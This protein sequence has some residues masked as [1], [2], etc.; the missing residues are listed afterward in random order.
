MGKPI[1]ARVEI[2][3]GRPGLTLNGQRVAPLLYGLTD[4][5]G[6]RWS[7]EEVPARNLA[8]FASSGLRLFQADLWFEQMIG[9]D[10]RLDI[11][12]ARR[13]VAG[14]LAACPDAAVML[15]LHVNAPQWWL[16]QHPDE[17]V[18]YADTEPEPEHPWSLQR[19]L[20]QDAGHPRRASFSSRAWL[21]WAGQHLRSFCTDL[22]ATREGGAVFGLQ[23][24][25]GVY[26]EWHQFGFL[27]HD[28]DHGPA[29]TA[30]FRAWLQTRY[31]SEEKLALAWAQP[32]LKWAAITP[33]DSAARETADCGILRDPRRQR[34]VIDYFHFLHGQL[35]D[36]ILALA[37][38]VKESW[39][40]PIITAAFFGYFH[41]MFG[42]LAAGGHL[43]LDRVLASPHL[44]CLCAPQSYVPT[45][46]APGGTGH[47]RGLID[48][49]R[50]AGKLWLDEMDQPTTVSGC[51]WDKTFVNTAVD[52]V[53]VQIRNILQPVT[54]GGGV[55]WYDF[56]PTAGT[57]EAVRYG[58]IGWWDDPRLQADAARLHALVSA[59]TN[60]P[61]ARPADVLVVHDPWSFAHTVGRRIP[62]AGAK[63]GTTPELQGDLVSPIAID[64]LVEGLH[65]SGLIHEEALLSEL[66]LLELAP[67]RLVIFATTP[68]LDT[69]Q[70]DCIRSR[71][72]QD[73]RHIVFTGFT[74]W[75]DGE[76]AEAGCAETTTGFPQRLHWANPATL[77]FSVNGTKETR[78]LSGAGELPSFGETGVEVIG[79]WQDGVA[80][81]V[82]RNEPGVTWW[83]FTVAPS[84]PALL[85]EIGR[86]AGCH[87]VNEADETTLLGAGLL[88]VHTLSGGT[89]TLRPPGGPDI[90]ADLPP[91]SSVVFDSVT[92]ERL[93]G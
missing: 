34:Q 46:R 29:A 28:P 19:P 37:E 75:S 62:P 69:T 43:A 36:T 78:N 73:D 93:H 12:L 51:P 65:Q 76:R 90:V 40:R 31:T 18:G 70:L 58:L 26:G 15:R 10:D 68:V 60:G 33:P 63:F 7:W 32:G 11:T 16:D 6:A 35:A 89:R 85:R 92:G 23:I 87:I 30:A 42:R 5:P 8:L 53:A 1:S 9:S 17:C 88:V 44:D 3:A 13:Q 49:V 47:A 55:W 84:K 86:S 20:A 83:A 66:P 57:P 24:A 71:L 56:G 22:A 38:M 27:H 74:G 79:R 61:L 82:R 59:R 80:A 39:P 25:N 50:R 2:E 91:R 77:V 41:S 52:D 72:G 21:E 48:P 67:F 54:R 4:S 64:A 14:V 45:A 81:A